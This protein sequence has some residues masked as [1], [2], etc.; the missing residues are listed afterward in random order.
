MNP[1]PKEL[2][3]ALIAREGLKTAL[4]L[5]AIWSEGKTDAEVLARVVALG[6]RTAADY[7]A[8]HQS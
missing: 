2:L 6:Q 5:V 1:M 3:Y 7:E 8:G 4:E